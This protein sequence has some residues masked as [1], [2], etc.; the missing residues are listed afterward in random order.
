MNKIKMK[1]YNILML[2]LMIFTCCIHINLLEAYNINKIPIIDDLEGKN[3][4]YYMVTTS[5]KKTY[6]DIFLAKGT[7]YFVD[8][9][10][11]TY[12]KMRLEN[13]RNT[14]LMCGSDNK[15]IDDFHK[16]KMVEEI[17]NSWTNYYADFKPS[18]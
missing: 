8:I 4:I 12:N 2:C 13:F 1:I 7:Q 5:G 11:T 9:D 15:C 18:K 17:L 16:Q 10:N 6:N 14:Y 3:S